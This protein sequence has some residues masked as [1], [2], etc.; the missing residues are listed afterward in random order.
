MRAALPSRSSS[1]S[2][3]GISGELTRD[4]SR[5]VRPGRGRVREVGRPQDVLD[6]DEVAHVQADLVVH[7]RARHVAVEV[8]AR[9]QRRL[10]K[11]YGRRPCGRAGRGSRGSSRGSARR[12]RSSAGEA[13]ERAGA[14]STTPRPRHSAS[15]G[16]DV[17]IA[18]CGVG[19]RRKT[20]YSECAVAEV[21]ADGDAG[22]LQHAPQ[23]VVDAP[24]GSRAARARSGSSAGA[25]TARR[26]RRAARPRTT[27]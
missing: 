18:V 25:P 23:R 15:A 12:T 3:S 19:S 26:G 10:G 11:S 20:S 5:G 4:D 13:L 21:V 8:L 22:L 1:R 14:G 9:L 7:E 16:S 24:R 27:A 6:A 2:S 17:K